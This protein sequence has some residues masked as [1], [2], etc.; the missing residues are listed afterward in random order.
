MALT[1]TS[2]MLRVTSNPDN[3]FMIDLSVQIEPTWLRPRG[4][5]AREG[6]YPAGAAH[7]RCRVARP[8]AGGAKQGAT[9]KTR[10]KAG[11]AHEREIVVACHFFSL[12]TPGARGM[13][14]AG[15][16]GMV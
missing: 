5:G 7:A 10:R 16:C 12:F 2:E 6:R 3:S 13:A 14:R 1:Y 8:I 11:T 9:A 15:M 4:I